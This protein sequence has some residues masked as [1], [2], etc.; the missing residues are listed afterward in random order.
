MANLY[1]AVN[2]IQITSARITFP[3]FGAWHGD[4]TIALPNPVQGDITITIGDLT[5]VGHSYR[6]A[7]FAGARSI[8]V[9]GGHGGWQQTVAP[10][11]YETP[12]GVLASTVLG[13]VATAVKETLDLAQDTILGSAF[14]RERCV[15]SRVLRQIVGDTWW[16][17]TNGVTKTAARSVSPITTDFQTIEYNG[18]KGRFVVSTESLHDWMPG[19]TFSSPTVTTQQ[20]ISSS[21]I[22]LGNDG[23]ARAEVLTN[24]ADIN[25]GDRLIA[26]LRSLIRE[27]FPSLTFMG[28]YEYS[29]QIDQSGF[30]DASPTNTELSLPSISM[31]RETFA[32]TSATLASGDLILVAFVNGD[33]TRPTCISAPPSSTLITI[34]NDSPAAAARAGDPLTINN[35]A[36]LL[37]S[38]SGAVCTITQAQF[39]AALPTIKTGS[40]QVRIG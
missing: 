30:V 1:A 34:G 39:E 8:R 35:P 36:G 25:A 19:R 14:V 32:F 31:I 3:Q 11:A 21:T 12:S 27:D 20:T 9:V 10:Q 24:T 18:S 16:I 28:I 5:L 17:D 15:A 38:V 2:G 26:E 33:P 6:M 29:V 22:V 40:T 4:V 7:S 13:D 37:G 23:I